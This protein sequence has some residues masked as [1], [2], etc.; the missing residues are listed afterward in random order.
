MDFRQLRMFAV[1]AVLLCVGAAPA[2]AFNVDGR[3]T[4]DANYTTVYNMDF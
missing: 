2:G 1:A 4:S 3:L